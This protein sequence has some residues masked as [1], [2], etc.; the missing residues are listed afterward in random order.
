MNIFDYISLF[1]DDINDN[2]KNIFAKNNLFNSIQKEEIS[3]NIS[4]DISGNNSEN[5][6]EDVICESNRS[7]KDMKEDENDIEINNYQKMS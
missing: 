5:S 4:K 3:E 1:N 7:Y 2:I 6:G